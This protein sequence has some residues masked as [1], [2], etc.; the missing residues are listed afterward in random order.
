MFN[1]FVAVGVGIIVCVFNIV[2]EKIE[3]SVIRLFFVVGEVEWVCDECLFGVVIVVFGLGLVYVFFLVEVLVGVGFGEGLLCELVDK[4]VCQMV[5]GVGVLFVVLEKDLQVLCCVVIFL[6]GMIQVVLDVLM[7]VGGGLLEFVCMVVNV[8]E[9]WFCQMGV[10][11]DNGQLGRFS[12]VFRFF[13][14]LCFR[15]IFLL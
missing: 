2:G 7:G 8:V 1:M 9:C 6:N 13:R 15:C 5:I 11:V 10:D 4:L 14:L 3:K 12:V